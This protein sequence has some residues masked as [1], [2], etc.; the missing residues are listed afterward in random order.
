MRLKFTMAIALL[1][2]FGQKLNA[3]LSGTVTVPGTYST[4]AAAIT[5]INT[6]GVNGALF[7]DIASG[8]TET[9]PVGGYT[10]TA[11]GTAANTITFRK[12]G[13][14]ANPLISAYAGGT[15]TP[16]TAIQDGIFNII[17]SDYIT[18][19]GIDLTDPN[20][21]NPATMEYG[22]GFFKASATDGC[23]NNSIINCVIT[24]NRINN[25][26]GGALAVDGS[27]GIN[28]VNANYSTQT[29]VIT[30]TSASGTNSNNKIYSNTIQNC[31]IGIALIG[32]AATSPFTNADTGNDIGGVSAATGNTIINYGGAAA[33][34][35]A[36]AGI[37]TLAQYNLNVS[38]NTVNNNN[39]SGVNHPSTLRGIYV[40][41]ATSANIAV[42]NNTITLNGAGTSSQLSGIENSSGS[43]AA[44]NTIAIVGNVITNSTYSTATSGVFYSI[45]NSASP[46]VLNVSNNIISNNT[47][48]GTGT[49]YGIETSSPVQVSMSNN[50]VG[51]NTKTGASGTM[52]CLK[53]VSPSTLTV[54]SNTVENNSYNTA[55][56]T[57]SIY[58]FYSLSSAVDVYLTNNIIRNLATPTTGSLYGIR[59]FGVTGTKLVTGNQVYG[60]TGAAG[61]SMYGIYMSTGNCNVSDNLVY[62]LNSNGG[63]A[64]TL[65]GIYISGGT[66]NT[67]FKNKVYD[68]SSSSTNPVVYGLYITGGTTNTVYNNFIGDLRATAAN[69]ANP[70]AGIYISGGTTDN[71]YYNTVHLNATSSGALFGSSAIYSSSTPALTLRN[72]VFINNSTPNGATGYAAAYRRSTTT[73]TSYNAASN[74]NIF[75]AGTPSANNLIMFDGTNAYQTLAAYQAT[76]APRDAASNTENTPFLSLVGSN[77]NFLHINPVLPSFTESGAVN[78]AG[79]LDDYDAQV[80]QGNPGYV[81]TGT[82]PDIGADEFN[83]NLPVCTSVSGGTIS[84]TTFTRCAGQT[85]SM[86]GT[87]LTTGTGIV[88]QWQVATTSG[89]PYSNVTGGT[90]ANTPNYTTGALTTGT[91]YYV[92]LT[93]CNPTSLTAT[94]NEATVTVNAVPTATAGSNSTLCAGQALNLTGGTDVGTNFAWSGPNGFTSTSQNPVIAVSSMTNNG[95][96]TLI[97]STPNCTATPVSTPVTVLAAP[98][99]LTVT[100]TSA[101]VCVGSSFTITAAGNDI[102]DTLSAGTQANIN[103]ATTGSGGYPAPYQLYYGGQRMQMLITAAELNTAGFAANSPITSVQFPV[104]S[105]GTAWGTTVNDLQNFQVSIGTTTLTNL[106][107]FQ[108]GLTNVIAPGSFTP[109]VGYNNVH[110][111]S[112]PFIWDGVSN[113][114]LETTFSNNLSGT[115]SMLVAQYNS[116]V[117][118][119]ATI[120]Y[121]ADNL[122]AAATASA[123]TV[124]FSYLSRPD[125]KLGG[126]TPVAYSWSPA[127]SL[128]SATSLTTVAT[129]A[130]STIYTLTAA[131]GVCTSN[132]TTSI[133]VTP[134]PSVTVAATPTAVCAGG[135]TTLSATG[136][137]SY[138]WTPAIPM[139][140]VITPTAATSYTV[141]GDNGCGTDSKTI[142]I[143]VNAN[144]T[145]TAVTSNT[146]ICAGN[147][148]TLSA[149]GASTYAWSGGA[150]TGANVTVSPSVTVTYTVVGTDVNGCTDS[151]SVLQTVS[152]CTGIE[153]ILVNSNG[154]NVFPNPTA[155]DV[156]IAVSNV[157]EGMQVEVLDALGKQVI[158]STITDNKTTLA[159]SEL[160]T[161][162][163]TYKVYNK[164]GLVKVGKIVKE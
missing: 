141:D 54:S 101:S 79:I 159:L 133:S 96:Y 125:F 154:I 58:G 146:I 88:Y 102:A 12:S 94:S 144:P 69:A 116:P 43:T 59:E 11:T 52:Y 10:L 86:G 140:G 73:L 119:T 151:T 155:T 72:N 63:T 35:N 104:V 49:F 13:A 85:I 28:F 76:V 114:I 45:Y 164:A 139:S 23:N 135:S 51:N 18:F 68:I 128:S 134:L 106:T 5:D 33:A 115:A 66:T 99:A 124:S 70:L 126:T 91:Y 4:V 84:P 62:S 2:I 121:R 157:T 9:A 31:N 161:G 24:L 57:G 36:S 147:S 67:I 27:R 156:V 8:Y 7:I 26:T 110:T 19:D 38:Y 29:T 160:A 112:T 17:G 56:S 149:N 95:L 117:S 82:A 93:T 105:K 127:S 78:I 42:T 16:G 145:V 97:V 137:T 32:F 20:A 53:T 83:Q 100:P 163:Y 123:T 80:R 109:N 138:T 74:N 90:G 103:T 131:N 64:G 150:G 98:G 1:A 39:G 44:S 75:Y 136:A 81:G 92:L 162:V 89:G 30:V 22:Y 108:S 25:A 142:T 60:F 153:N 3:Q 47:I 6:Q 130:A 152:P 65:A 113:V 50:Y 46:A 15:G 122:S 129:P 21:A 148:A 34:T 120:V 118:Y 158:Q 40:N 14:G 87:G 107:S 55:G 37:R 71:I 41:T 48:A 77:A 111:F 61:A 143:N 132:A